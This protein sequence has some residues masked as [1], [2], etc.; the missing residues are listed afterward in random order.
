MREAYYNKNVKKIVLLVGESPSFLTLE[1]AEDFMKQIDILK[2]DLSLSID[3]MKN[4][5]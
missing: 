5:K 2:S 4:D 3:D 1:E